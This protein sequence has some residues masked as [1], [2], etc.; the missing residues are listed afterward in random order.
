MSKSSIP[1][2]SKRAAIY[3]RVS[4]EEQAEKI[5]PDAQRQDC[6]ALAEQQGYSIVDIYVDAEKYRVGKKLVEPS[7]EHADRPQFKRMLADARARQFDVIIAWKQDRLIRGLRPLVLVVDLLEETNIG[8]ELVKETFDK[9][10]ML[11]QAVVAKMELDNIRERTAMGMIARHK[12]GKITL[13]NPP[14]GYTYADGNLYVHEIEAVWV[15]QIWQWFGEGVGRKGIRQRLIAAR[16]PQ[17]VTGARSW[18]TR[19]QTPL[20]LGDP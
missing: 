14:Y 6:C 9:R 19:T 8:I 16:A 13:C 5:S 10:T 7:G 12:A 3:V 20:V 17:S 18:R 2:S 11:L 4:T 15:R 1:R